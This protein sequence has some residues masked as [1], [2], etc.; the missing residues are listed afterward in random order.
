MEYEA[1]PRANDQLMKNREQLGLIRGASW[2]ERS[3][4]STVPLDPTVFSTPW[5]G[6]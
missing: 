6:E 1:D 5:R 4:R 2:P 3:F